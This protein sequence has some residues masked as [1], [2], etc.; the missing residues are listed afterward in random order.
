[1]NYTVSVTSTKRL[2]G[3]PMGDV[4][5][6]RSFQ[7]PPAALD[8]FRDAVAKMADECGMEVSA[9]VTSF[10]RGVIGTWQF[11]GRA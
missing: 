1:M 10:R 6:T 3:N 8:Q 4:V 2:P 7:V 5:R 9:T 11:G